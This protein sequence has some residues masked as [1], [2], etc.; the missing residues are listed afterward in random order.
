[1]DASTITSISTTYSKKVPI[2]NGTNY[3]MWRARM[4]EVF[5]TMGMNVVKSVHEGFVPLKEGKNPAPE[6]LRQFEINEKT[7][8]ACACC[9]SV[10]MI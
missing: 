1:M 10:K 8:K 9:K 7:S 2:F 3:H 4:Q 6:E 5:A